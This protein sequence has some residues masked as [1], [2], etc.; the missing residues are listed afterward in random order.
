[1]MSAIERFRW[2]L[3]WR[4]PYLFENIHIKNNNNR[5]GNIPVNQF[6]YIEY[7][8]YLYMASTTIIQPRLIHKKESGGG[9]GGYTFIRSFLHSLGVKN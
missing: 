4:F 2:A 7:I 8:K 3:T 1:M 5:N 9:G 6:R